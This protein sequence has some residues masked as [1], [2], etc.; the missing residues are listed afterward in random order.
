MQKP[1]NP[2]VSTL[3]EGRPALSTV[4]WQHFKFASDGRNRNEL[5]GCQRKMANR[6]VR[7]CIDLMG[8]LDGLCLKI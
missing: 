3:R 8:S 4:D 1:M 5:A 6:C 2:G 7:V